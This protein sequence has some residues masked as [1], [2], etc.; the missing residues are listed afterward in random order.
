MPPILRLAL[1][2]LAALAS[3]PAAAQEAPVAAPAEA[4][5]RGLDGLALA[6]SPDWT[7]VTAVEVLAEGPP[8]S[9]P[10][11]G[12]IGGGGLVFVSRSQWTDFG[13]DGQPRS[14]DPEPAVVSR[15]PL[16]EPRP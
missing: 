4:E 8:L 3:L 10:T 15:L 11:T 9:E 12:V 14:P 1:P 13:P 2:A 5:L 7:A 16:P 6:L